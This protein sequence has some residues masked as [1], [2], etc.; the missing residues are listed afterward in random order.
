MP[1]I[2]SVDQHLEDLKLFDH[3]N[4]IIV[5]AIRKLIFATFPKVNEVV[6]YNGLLYTTKL[7]I[8]G[9]FTYKD[10]VSMEFSNGSM[11]EDKDNLL[12][13]NGKF[14]RHLKFNTAE[15]IIINNLRYFLDQCNYDT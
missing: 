4:Y 6:K 14:R 7:G 2:K 8:G 1:N 3:K 13:G 12:E 11:L 10:H 15:D 5:E 9:I